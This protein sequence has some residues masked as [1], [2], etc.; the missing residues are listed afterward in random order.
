MGKRDKE[1]AS[2]IFFSPDALL[3]SAF[4]L[5]KAACVSSGASLQFLF[6]YSIRFF[7]VFF[8]FVLFFSHGGPLFPIAPLFGI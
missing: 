6:L 3:F 4:A 1:H 5:V 2:I 8:L 7:S